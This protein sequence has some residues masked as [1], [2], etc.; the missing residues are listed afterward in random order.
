MN[1]ENEQLKI[2]TKEFAHRCVKLGVALPDNSLGKHLRG[3]LNRSFTSVA[4]N[5]RAAL[6]SQSKAMFKS[7]ISIVLEEVKELTAIFFATRK[8]LMNQ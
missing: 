1:A 2:R 7:K 5:N 3:Q 6:L 4:A 8:T